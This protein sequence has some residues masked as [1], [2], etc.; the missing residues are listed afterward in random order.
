MPVFERQHSMNK[1]ILYGHGGAYN[2]GAEAIVKT[3]IAG[4]RNFDC[5]SPVILSTHFKAQDEEFELPV[6]QYIE[7]NIDYVRKEKEE[8]VRG[9]YTSIIYS[10]TAASFC[11]DAT[12]LSVG[13]DN[14]CYPGWQ[15]WKYIHEEAKR[16]G[17]K[18][19]LWSCSIDPESI[20]K[21]MEETLRTYDLIT[22]RESITYQALLEH[23]F[24]NTVLC[25]DVAFL[26]NRQETPLPDNF[27]IGNTVAINISPL[28]MRRESQP[29]IIKESLLYAMRYIMEKT[30][31]QI[32]LVP[33]VMMAIDNDYTAL[34]ELYKSG[35]ENGW[36]NRLCLISPDLSAAQYKYI[37]S[38]CRFGIFARTHASI[39]AYSSG[40][41]SLA[42]GYSVKAKGIAKDLG[43]IDYVLPV[44]AI[45]RNSDLTE[46]FQKLMSSEKEIKAI[47]THSK[48][49][50]KTA[51]K[52]NWFYLKQILNIVS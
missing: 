7:R 20:T 15:S 30:D 28:V 9:K 51:A 3:T 35:K 37:I 2:H 45:K 11:P 44:E 32:A 42:L 18:D 8:G 17:A 46:S 31:M 50:A 4:I 19:I 40:I 22:A 43:V 26:L 10:N 25:A 38:Q 1:F 49:K 6:D 39:A 16:R 48:E 27:S 21:E 34:S 41:P 52:D 36:E 13:G 33:H 47:L 29:G 12:A 24:Q 14:Y 23:G 5:N